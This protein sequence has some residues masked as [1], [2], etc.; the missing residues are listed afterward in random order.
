MINLHSFF[1][2]PHICTWKKKA[3]Q[4]Q[5]EAFASS[6]LILATP[7]IVHISLTCVLMPLTYV[8]H[9]YNFESLIHF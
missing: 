5:D 2:R 7:M 4:N 1:T 8:L 6:C 3:L 9:I